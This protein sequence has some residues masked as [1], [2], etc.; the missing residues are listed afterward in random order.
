MTDSH[1]NLV[2]EDSSL[3]CDELKDAFRSLAEC[4]HQEGHHEEAEVSGL[5]VDLLNVASLLR[6]DTESADCA[7]QIVSYCQQTALPAITAA[8]GQQSV[9]HLKSDIDGQFGE[10][11]ALLAPEERFQ[12]T[13]N[14]DWL[15]D[16]SAAEEAEKVPTADPETADLSPQ[17]ASVGLEL[18]AALASLAADCEAP[19]NSDVT[20]TTPT[21]TQADFC[22]LPAPPASL[23][24]IDDPEMV[25]AYADDAQLCLSEMEAS[26]LNLDSGQ[27]PEESLRNFCRQLHTLKG[28]SGTVGLA[29][30]AAYLH[31]VE[32]YIEDTA[33]AAIEADQLFDVVDTVRRQLQQSGAS[34]ADVAMEPVSAEPSQK[35]AETSNATQQVVPDAKPS[36][37]HSTA[38]TD[39]FVRVEASRLERL[40]DL[41]AE[42]VMVRNRRDTYVNSLQAIH[43][44]FNQCASRTRALTP[45]I[46]LSTPAVERPASAEGS[47]H[48]SK[49]RLM[50][51]SLNEIS[52]DITELSR[53]LH[54]VADPL[55]SDNSAISHLIGR[56]RQELMEL[57]RLPVGGL[58]QRL[59]R[60]IRDAARAENKQVE[61]VVEGQG[62][63]AERAVQERLF[64][65]LLHLVRNAVSHGLESADQ[66]LAAGKPATGKITLSAWSDASSLTIEVRDDGRG[67]DEEKLEARG[68]ELGL[69]P[70]GE[71]V[72]QTQLRRLIFQSGFS[73]RA[74]VTEIS[75]RGV[76]MDVVDNWVRKLRGRIDV[77]SVTGQGTTFRLHIPLRSAIE[78]AMVVKAGG[79]LFA[80]PMHS[81]SSTSD[82][83]LDPAVDFR[84]VISLGSVLGK[85]NGEAD[86]PCHVTLRTASGHNGPGERQRKAVTIAVDSI[87]GVE[88]V[89]VRSLPSILQRNELFAGV[90]LSGH[91]ETVLLLDV[92]RLIDLVTADDT[93]RGEV[94]GSRSDLTAESVG[95]N[96]RTGIL[97]VD[98]SVVVRRVLCRRLK[99]QGYRVAEACNGREALDVLKAE[100]FSA[101][102]T[103]I[104][105]P[106][107]NGVEL[108]YEVKRQKRFHDLPVVVLSGRDQ[109]LLPH[110]LQ[111]LGPTAVLQKPVTDETF[112]ALLETFRRE[113]V[114]T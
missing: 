54:D 59:Q 49:V 35:P 5:M 52:K 46:E 58:F 43:T 10:L 94:S 2:C 6:A 111:Q 103:D 20:P 104:D 64:E 61:I 96:T 98:D 36:S 48:A 37:V 85:S 82:S 88:E 25:A 86:R 100:V 67:L 74:S 78:H 89:V 56:F 113:G 29:A 11:L 21:A 41:L 14:T 76:G 40:M 24:I 99:N 27:A 70:L 72:S 79:Q 3:P 91:A 39:Q 83:R 92:P 77:D 47:R 73:T 42:L 23:E 34:S 65:P 30:L 66:R 90:T 8:N 71:T 4:A 1:N 17:P 110:D 44:E 45:A 97:V 114:L 108:L 102:V 15:T 51:C 19:C 55:A 62:A 63:R 68:R 112:N 22:G 69:L 28:A 107:M 12:C 7:D 80:L 33:A 18:Q 93:G 95:E 106:S 9:D 50:S 81:V 31:Q 87:V 109:H 84:Q 13:P 26:L 53:S 38:A 16:F 105:M 57:R 101:I 32:S 75:G 60:S